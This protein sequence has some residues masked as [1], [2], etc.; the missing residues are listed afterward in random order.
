MMPETSNLDDFL[1]PD[2]ETLNEIF[3]GA[4]SSDEI[5]MA[6]RWEMD[7]PQ[8]WEISAAESHHAF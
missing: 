8:L 2:S 6:T 1:L 4:D 5:S 3:F 7:E